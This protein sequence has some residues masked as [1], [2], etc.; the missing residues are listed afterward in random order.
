MVDYLKVLA[1]NDTEFERGA[2]VFQ[3]AQP[4]EV[5]RPALLGV[6]PNRPA[7]LK[8]FSLRN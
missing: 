1:K 6:V 8:K 3:N 7:G 4:L 2:G 5:E